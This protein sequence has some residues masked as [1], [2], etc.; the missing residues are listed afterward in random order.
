MHDKMMERKKITSLKEARKEHK[1]ETESPEPGIEHETVWLE[2]R[3]LTTTPTQRR[4]KNLENR[5]T[6]KKVV[7]TNNLSRCS[8]LMRIFI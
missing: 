8:R 1:K 6:S 3:N 2:V 5:Q 7:S 4:L